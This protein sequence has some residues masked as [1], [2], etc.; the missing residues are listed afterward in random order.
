MAQDFPPN[1]DIFNG[2]FGATPFKG[3][4]WVMYCGSKDPNP[5]R[6]GCQAMQAARDF[7]RWRN[8]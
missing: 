7:P 1:V 8:R 4:H 5:D 6:D 3:V 2:K